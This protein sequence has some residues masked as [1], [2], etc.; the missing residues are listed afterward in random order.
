MASISVKRSISGFSLIMHN[1]HS[2][3]RLPKLKKRMVCYCWTFMTKVTARIQRESLLMNVET[4]EKFAKV[5]CFDPCIFSEPEAVRKRSYKT[6]ITHTKNCE[7]MSVILG[8][9][10]LAECVLII[11]YQERFTTSNNHP[12]ITKLYD[13]QKGHAEERM[14][15]LER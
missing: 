5:F 15:A 2:N 3:W 4:D 11:Y 14:A 8:N 1:A 10:L 6:E 12:A 7:C 9:N 13:L